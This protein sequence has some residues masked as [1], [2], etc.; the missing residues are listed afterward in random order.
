MRTPSFSYY[1]ARIS[2]ACIVQPRGQFHLLEKGERQKKKS[3]S[4]P[5]A[6]HLPPPLPNWDGTMAQANAHWREGKGMWCNMSNAWG[7]FCCGQHRVKRCTHTFCTGVSICK[8]KRRKEK[9]L[10]PSPTRTH[11]QTHQSTLLPRARL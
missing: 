2:F 9:N 11:R 6:F 8:K 1:F 10:I 7:R 3:I 5:C 4:C